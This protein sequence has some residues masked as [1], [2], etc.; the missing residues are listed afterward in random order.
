VFRSFVLF[1]WVFAGSAACQGSSSEPDTA[2]CD[3]AYEHVLALELRSTELHASTSA[4]HEAALRRA[5]PAASSTCRE[6][7]ARCVLASDDLAAARSCAT[8]NTVRAELNR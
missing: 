7:E 6:S 5:M 2:V 1:T 4:A 8:A 3:Q